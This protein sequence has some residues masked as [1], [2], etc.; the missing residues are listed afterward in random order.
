MVVAVFAT[1]V[2]FA[3]AS[4]PAVD[5]ITYPVI[6]MNAFALLGLKALYVVLAA[7]RSR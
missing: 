2:V 7:S 5:G 3:I 6:T 4:V 1:D